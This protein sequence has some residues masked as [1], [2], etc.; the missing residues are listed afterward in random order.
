MKQSTDD[1]RESKTT[2][3]DDLD[4]AII[5]FAGAVR[6]ET[7][8]LGVNDPSYEVQP[9]FSPFK[10]KLQT[11]IN[12]QVTKGRLI[13]L[14]LLEQLINRYGNLAVVPKGDLNLYKMQRLKELEQS[15]ADQQ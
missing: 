9:L 10:A 6:K 1:I 5:S 11:Y 3:I 7:L 2:D 8:A 4:T 13:E 15:Y 12:K 14:D